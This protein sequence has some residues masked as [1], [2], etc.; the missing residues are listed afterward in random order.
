LPAAFHLGPGESIPVDSI[1]AAGS[2]AGIAGTSRG[3]ARDAR[4]DLKTRSTN[5]GVWQERERERGPP[6]EAGN[7]SLL[8]TVS[9]PDVIPERGSASDVYTAIKL[10]EKLSPAHPRTGYGRYERESGRSA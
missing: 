3:I 9:S 1:I 6:A 7:E 10:P 5:A 8:S 2:S 4:E